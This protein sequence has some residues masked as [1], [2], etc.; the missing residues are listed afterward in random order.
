MLVGLIGAPMAG[1]VA[2]D[3]LSDAI[4]RQKALEK[5]IQQQKDQ[6]AKLNALQADL[7]S[8]IAATRRDLAAVNA[9]LTAVKAQINT[10]VTRIEEV[11][12]R[13]NNLVL[14]L[15]ILD[16]SLARLVADE[17]QKAKELAERKALLADR[18][19]TAYETDQTSPLELF[20]S[21]GSFTDVLS[22][23]SYNIDVAE[24]DKALAEQITRDA[25]TLAAMHVMVETTRGATDALRAETAAQKAELDQ[26]LV[27]LQEAQAALKVLEAETAK[28]LAAQRSAFQK[29]GQNKA[30]V[31]QAMR[32][33]RAAQA[34]LSRK[35]DRL[36][37][38]QAR[39]GNIPSRFNGTM[40]WPMAGRISGE[41]GCSTFP[42]YG[43][44]N[45]C[46]HYHNGIDIVAPA[47]TPVKAAA[48]GV[49]AYIGWNW[50]DGSDPA[51]IVVVAHSSN[52][53]SW[54]AHMQ[55]QRPVREGQAVSK[56]QVIGYE[57]NTGNSTG[58]HL[59]W[60]VELNG[61]FTNPRLFL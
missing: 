12:V 4:A 28:V 22:E 9:D 52:L 58:A 2:G 54:Y 10:M 43:P 15:R 32:R 50:A 6:V 35:I 23:V 41:Y 46:A 44:G 34:E 55:P 11:K 31:E 42:W 5:Q 59:H 57:G 33:A 20:L 27:A 45:G 30:A 24:Q 48:A 56:G 29:L 21:G 14:E 37:E 8:Q 16:T 60:M 51:W 36:V 38:E 25:E 3:E 13:Y 49:V 61:S 40:T 39:R 1:P 7:N 26:A 18:I 47:G 19:R 17:A 53:R